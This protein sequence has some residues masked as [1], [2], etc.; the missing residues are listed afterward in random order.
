MSFPSITNH[1][2]F[3]S[4]HY[5]DAVI[6]NDLKGLRG[7]WDTREQRDEPTPRRG[8]RALRGPFDRLKQAA[9]EGATD[10]GG[11]ALAALHDATLTA[12]GH[13]PGRET[14]E[15]TRGETVGVTIP[16]AHATT[17][18]TGLRLLALE[19]HYA[20]SPEEARGPD[21]RLVAP[22]V[23]DG[24][25]IGEPT[26]AISLAFTVDDPP[27]H[28]LLLAGAVVILAARESWAE[29]RYLAVDLD[30][31]LGR[32]D[33]KAKGELDTIAA[34]FSRDA[35]VPGAAGEA[36][37]DELA[38]SSHKQ[39]VGVSADL[40]EGV[41]RSVEDIA[42][43]IVAQRLARNLAVYSEPDIARRLARESLRFLYR[44]LFLLY[45][46]ARPELGIVPSLAEGYRDGYGLD[47]LRELALAELTTSHALEGTHLHASLDMLFALVNDGY[48]H[49]FAALELV[50][51]DDVPDDTG[52][53][54]EPLHS[55]LF[56]PRA[57]P[58]LDSIRL[59]NHVVQRVLARLLLTR[60]KR[61]S[62][63]RFVS[64]ATLGINQLGAVYEGLMAYTG[65]LADE[66]L[67]EVRKPGSEEKH[68]T[69]VVPVARADEYPDEVFVTEVGDDGVARRVRHAK[70]S[71]VYRL[72]GRDRQR[73]ASYYTPEVLTRCVVKHALE[74]LLDQDGHTTSA[75]EL[76]ELTI[77]EPALGSGAFLNE[78]INQLSAEYLARRQ[79]ELGETIDPDAYAAALQKVKTHFA[80]HQSYGVDLNATAVELA[81]VSLWLNAM[82][83]G[84]RAPWFGLHLRRGNSL[85][86][87]RRAVY[88]RAQ[89]AGRKWLKAVPEDRALATDTLGPDEVH[90]FLLP[91]DGWGAVKGAKEAKELRPEA[92]QQL[93]AWHKAVTAAIS[94][95]DAARYAALARRVEALW[96]LAGARLALAERD[97]RRPLKLYGA[98]AATQKGGVATTRAEIE[99]SLGGEDTPLARLRLVMDAWCA[100]WFW[101]LEPSGDVTPPTAA[102]WLSALEGLLGIDPADSRDT[103]PAQIDLFAD[104]D[105]LEAREEE[106]A[107]GLLM[108]SVEQVREQHPWLDVVREIADR[109][110]FFHWELTFTT[111]FRRGGFDL[112]VGNPP[113]VR[114]RWLD[115][116]VLAELEPWF[117]LAG[118]SDRAFASRRTE[119]LD[120]PEAAGG[121]LRELSLAT[122]AGALLGAT[123]LRPE[124]AGSQLNLYMVFMGESWR[125]RSPDGIVGLLHPEGHFLDPKSVPLRAAVYPRLRRH[126]H[127]VNEA[128]LFDEVHHMTDFGVHVYGAP[129]PIA[130][131]MLTGAQI[132]ATVDG[133]LAHDGEGPVPGAKTVDGE[134]DRRPH[135]DRV[136]VVD[137]AALAGF[138]SL[139]DPA[140]TQAGDARL[141]RPYTRADVRA[142]GSLAR[143]RTRVGS[144]S[145]RWT[146][147]WHEKQAKTDG[148]IEWRTE[149]PDSWGEAILQ[150]PHFTL[151]APFAKQPN[152][153]CKNNLDWSAWDLE[154]LPDRVVPRT[155][156]Q[157]AS[158]VDRYRGEAPHWDGRPA[159]GRFRLI[160]RSFV[161][162]T[163]VR[164]VQAV[165]IPPGPLHIHGCHTRWIASTRETALTVGLWSSVPVDFL[166]KTSGVANFQDEMVQ[167]FPFPHP[168]PYDDALLL[169]TL[170][171]NCLTR[172]YEPLW[173]E[174]LEPGAFAAESWTVDDARLPPLGASAPGWARDLP[175][176]TALARRHALVELDALGALALG[177][178]ADELCGIYRTTFGVLRK[179]EHAMRHDRN[180]REV[181]KDVWTAYE[182]DPHGAD[183]GRYVPPFTKPD[184]EAEMRQAYAVF[185]ERYGGGVA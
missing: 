30:L 94:S 178:S 133:S 145:Y 25:E 86:G 65:F 120:D 80:L 15:T 35:L 129:R 36:V 33:T 167:R 135:A 28:V 113:W 151:C 54:F 97:L 77:C 41:R 87:A 78:A 173:D 179:Y 76:L 131:R 37:I 107:A 7:D 136:I 161:P 180:G 116:V 111:V 140:G 60:E 88:P 4:D 104:L 61:G 160:H 14:I 112:Q 132:P 84:L 34:L 83:P 153:G 106:L 73:S 79:N 139:Y 159:A 92:V 99:A 52:L 62:E 121:Y 12:L 1:Q 172:D 157:R 183:L 23:L 110:G 22:L 89:L 48:H 44:I 13:P 102:D 9:E 31:A 63:R 39:A 40:R 138:S 8:V 144:T 57:T 26:K 93:K 66:D 123:E 101:P 51:D 16:V 141:V 164:T 117:G 11:E 27:R 68:G 171:L 50:E 124:L 166:F 143:Q 56:G 98:P 118:G 95:A 17:L 170:R 3:F 109:E 59:R 149:V 46:E 19:A 108:P 85:I 90:H 32:N 6:A 29:G 20:A 103:E 10:R 74:E 176:R 55:E 67:H 24:E 91:A 162:S 69:W 128:R 146:D 96:E 64:Y 70:G 125:R 5:L 105:A 100:L 81:E 38:T 168:S 185:A 75:D 169:R 165:I 42:D 152:E 72:S 184:R 2:E 130:F 155:N 142:L 154:T 175:L 82:H 137:E 122:G 115:D 43:E 177:M 156:Y 114:P 119:V 53:R 45:A 148:I 150:G 174:L 126:W 58:L 181:P 21:H 134:W 163:G 147:G 127:F 49:E 18:P 182:Q 47:R 158:S 71:F